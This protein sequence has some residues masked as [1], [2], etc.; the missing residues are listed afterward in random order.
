[1]YRIADMH[2]GT[3]V[4]NNVLVDGITHLQLDDKGPTYQKSNTCPRSWT[5]VDPACESTIEDGDSS[6]PLPHC[7]PLRD[8]HLHHHHRRHHLQH[9]SNP[10]DLVP[11]LRILVLR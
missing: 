3:R 9:H 2:L 4:Y 7:R 11:H 8:L 5:P 1:M 10:R 6:S